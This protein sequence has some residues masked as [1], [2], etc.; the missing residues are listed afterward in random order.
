METIISQK[1]LINDDLGLGHIKDIE[2]LSFQGLFTSLRKILDVKYTR[3][4]H[5]DS[6]LKKCKGR[7]FKAINECVKKCLRINVPKFP[8]NF[9]TNISIEYNQKFLDFTMG[10]LYSYFHLLPYSLDDIMEKN[11]CY[12]EKEIYLKYIFLS[13]MGSLYFQYIKSKQYKRMIDL[14]KTKKG[15]KIAKLYQ[16]VSDNFINYYVFSRAH[17]KK[18][19]KNGETEQNSNLEQS[20]DNINNNEK[21]PSS[22]EDSLV[23]INT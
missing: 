21:S 1:F 19:N 15:I 3:K 8:Q 11:Y 23:L 2:M 13:K 7:F 14:I 5:I 10:D 18:S 17:I 12:K 9:I 16:F 6:I 4:L 22:K 20:N